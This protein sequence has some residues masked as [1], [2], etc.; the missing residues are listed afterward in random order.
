M[1]IR[2]R[3]LTIERHIWTILFL[4]F[5]SVLIVIFIKD[6]GGVITFEIFA[7]ILGSLFAAY[8]G[9]LKQTIDNDKVFKDLFKSFNSRYSNQINDLLN[10]IRIDKTYEITG[11]D[12][13]LIIDYFN[14]CAEEFLW[15]RKGRIPY[16]IW[17]AWEAG[18]IFN[19]SIPTVK[20][21]FCEETKEVRQKKSY[22]GFVEYI[23]PILE[24]NKISQ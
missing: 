9:T 14:L 19:L 12:K 1:R 2:E 11:S 5:V 3:L 4:L 17:K 23:M 13:L 22:Y 24:N 8:F 6:S 10:R 20:Q 21:L 15:F 18:I 7:G 16:K